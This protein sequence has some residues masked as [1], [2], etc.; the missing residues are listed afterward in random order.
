MSRRSLTFIVPVRNDAVRLQRCLASIAA[1][2]SD[3]SVDVVV[4]DNGSND[5]SADVAAANGATVIVVPGVT[6]AQ[7]RNLAAA[8]ATGDLL[9]FVDADHEIDP[10][11]VAAAFELFADSSVAA[12]GA[13]CH[14]PVDAN[15]VQRT[16]DRFRPS[17]IGTHETEWL[18]SGNLIVRR[19][20][21]A[22]VNGFDG[23]L[24]ACED[25]DLCGRLR[26]EGYRLFADGRLRN[27]H[28]GDPR[29]LKALFLGELW[30]GR[31]NLRVTFR[32][33]WTWRA[34]PSV[35][36]PIIDLA[37]LV[38]IALAAWVGGGVALGA[39]LIVS[40]FV[41]LRAIRMALNKGPAGLVPFAQNLVVAAVY[42]TARALALVLRATHRT[43]RE[44]ARE[45]AVA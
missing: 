4:A 28:L 39:A 7:A 10:A 21:F 34:L 30:R 32:G 18:G 12:G 38:A 11:W 9:A 24:E 16:Y 20:V 35:L 2:R 3:G 42:D 13:P 25:V 44:L 14:P 36:I 15:W 40:G 17:V 41:A 8:R 26:S 33:P 1:S 22:A 37:C 19:E 6:V 31:N 43:R 23:T 5:E 45:Q 27:V 29:T